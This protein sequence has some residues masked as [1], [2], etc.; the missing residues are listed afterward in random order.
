MF[1]RIIDPIDDLVTAGQCAVAPTSLDV[2]VDMPGLGSLVGTVAGVRGDVVHTVTYSR[3]GP[4]ARLIAWARLLALTATWPARPFQA[5]TI[6][7][8][9][10]NRSAISLAKVGPLG[11]DEQTRKAAAEQHLRTLVDLFRRGMSEPLPLYCKTS[12]AWAAA[13]ASGK[14]ADGA[15]R[16]AAGAWAT[17]YNVEKEDKDAEHVMVLGDALS[18]EAL[19]E[20]SG[21]PRDD[22]A[23]WDPSESWRFGLYARR[24]WDGLLAHEEMVDR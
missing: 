23:P 5:L 22:E 6:G 19:V 18:F 9:L 14:D 17:D 24:L 8:N 20:R 7:R 13:V 12:A 21:V 16:A 11:P 4:A 2:H 15:S 1:V 10:G 3:L